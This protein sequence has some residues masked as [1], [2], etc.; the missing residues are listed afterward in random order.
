MGPFIFAGTGC[1]DEPTRV[2]RA[3]ARRRRRTPEGYADGGPERERGMSGGA[4]HNPTLCVNQQWRV[5]FV[6][7]DSEATDAEIVDYH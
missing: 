2:R 3:D 6:W 1:V 7:K 5:C 4:A